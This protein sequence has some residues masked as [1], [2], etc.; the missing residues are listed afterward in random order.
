MIETR[1]EE[2]RES[3]KNEDEDGCL[4][5]ETW[6]EEIRGGEENEG[7]DEYLRSRWSSSDSTP[8]ATEASRSASKRNILFFFLPRLV[9]QAPLLSSQSAKMVQFITIL[10]LLAAASTPLLAHPVPEEAA[11]KLVAR[12]QSWDAYFWSVSSSLLS[13]G[14]ARPNK[15]ISAHNF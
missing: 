10:T 2:S 9:S 15:A 7:E 11:H 14:D 4:L 5:T 3:G 1:N 12:V 13:R 8:S 6:I